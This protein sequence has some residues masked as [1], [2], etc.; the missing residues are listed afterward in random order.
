MFFE[1]RGRVHLSRNNYMFRRFTALFFILIFI[2]FDVIRYA[3]PCYAVDSSVL[4]SRGVSFLG[5]KSIGTVEESF[6]GVSGKTIFFIQDA[7]DSLEAQENIARIISELVKKN[8]I[9]TVFE[10]G[11][12][13]PV[14]SDRFFGFIKD[15]KI[16]QKVSYF[17]LDKLRIGGAEYAHINR[18][19]DFKLIGVESLKLYSQNIHHYQKAS[20][21]RQEVSQDLKE[22]FAQ[23]SNLA[24]QYFPKNF[25]AWLLINER[26]ADG[27][28]PLLNYLKELQILYRKGFGGRFVEQFDAKYPAISILLAAEN[29]HDP[30]LVKQLNKMNFKEVFGEVFQLEQDISSGYLQTE[31][32]RQIFTYYQELQLLG[33]LNQFKL[34][35]PEYEAVKETLEKFDT[36]KLADFA[37][38]L[39]HRSLILS[40]EWERSIKDAV[41]FYDVANQREHSIDLHVQNFIKNKTENAAVLVFGGFHASG[42]KEILRAHQIS[43]RVIL[44]RIDF[45]DKKHQ[46][47]YRQ[48]MSV[49][50]YAF[51]MPFLAAQANKPPS[52]YF[53]AATS[54]KEEFALSE[55][56]AIAS[57]VQLLGSRFVTE[58][59]EKQLAS[60]SF[61]QKPQG[62]TKKTEVSTRSETRNAKQVPRKSSKLLSVGITGASGDLGATLGRFFESKNYPLKLVFRSSDSQR[63][64]SD[65]ALREIS[66]D[67][68]ILSELFDREK[69]QS[70]IKNSAV[71]YHLAAL[72]GLDKDIKTYAENFK[73][74]GLAAVGLLKMAEELN[75]GQ[76]FIFASTQRVYGIEQ[77]PMAVQW[78]DDALK[79]MTEHS[80]LFQESNYSGAMD[81]LMM[82]ILEKHPFPEGI[83]PYELAKFF[84][85]KYIQQSKL[86]NAVAVRVSSIYGPGNLSGRK[87]Q[88]MIE[89]RLLGKTIQ[90]KREIRDYIYIQDA[91]EVLYKLGFKKN[92]PEQSIMDL[93]SGVEISAEKIWEMIVKHTPEARGKIEWQGNSIPANPQSSQWGH[94][95]L[96]RDF[97]YI[98]TGIRN[99]V[100]EAR[101]RLSLQ[102]PKMAGQ[103]RILVIDAGGTSTRM[104]VWDGEKLTDQVKFPTINY[105]S[106]Q[107]R[108]KSLDQMQELWLESLEQRI[109]MYREQ[110]PDIQS[111][112]MGFAGP[113]SEAGDL[114]ES[115][116]IW[117]AGQRRIFN[118][119]LQ[120]RWGLP[121]LV[122]NDLTAAVYRYGKSAPF[123]KMRTI[124]LITVS[125]GIGSKLFDIVHGSVVIDQRGRAGEIGHTIVD[126]ARNAIRGEGL[127]GELNAYSSGRGLANLAKRLTGQKKFQQLY[128]RSILKREIEKSGQTIETID[129]DLLTQ[130]LVASIKE[131]DDFSLQVMK[132]SIGYFIRVL[133]PFIL[134]NAPDAIVWMG[135]IAEHLGAVYLD[136]VISQLLDKGLYGYTREDLG[137][138]FIM[139]EKDDENGLRG[140]GLMV[141]DKKQKALTEAPY[142]PGYVRDV[143]DEHGHTT[144]EALARND[145]GYKNYFERGIFD[146]SNPTLANLVGQRN[147]IFV[148]EKIMADKTLLAI[149]SYAEHHK[150]KLKGSIQVLDGGEKIKSAEEVKMLTDYAQDQKLDRNGVFVV[151]GGGAIMDM[152]GM[153][154]S[155]FRRGVKYVRIPT[156]LLGQ[157]DAAVGVK[158]G[159]D[160]RTAKNFLGAFYPPEATITDTQFLDSLPQRH[161]QSGLA[162]VIKVALISNPS[163]FKTLEEYGADFLRKMPEHEK[164]TFIRE[165][166]IELLKH[167]QRDF[168]EHNLMRHVDFG[169]VLAH[170]FE[171]MTNYELT[172]GEAVAID[173]LMSAFIAHERGMLSDKDFDRI[174]ALHAKLNLPYF[175]PALNPDRAW[176]GLE[177]SKAH[178]GGRLMMVVPIGIGQTA[179]VD[180][181]RRKEVVSA[182]QF[183]Q[184]RQQQLEETTMQHRIGEN[185]PPIE[186]RHL[187]AY[188]ESLP[189]DT[190]YYLSE[191]EEALNSLCAASVQKVINIATNKSLKSTVRAKASSMLEQYGLKLENE[192][193]TVILGS[194]LRSNLKEVRFVL[195]NGRFVVADKPRTQN[196]MEIAQQLLGKEVFVFDI[197]GTLITK[198]GADPEIVSY[199]IQLLKQHKTV[200]I[201]TVR[202]LTAEDYFSNIRKGEGLGILKDIF[203]HPDFKPEMLE[204]LYAY[205][206]V[207]TYKFKFRVMARRHQSKGWVSIEPVAMAQFYKK[208]S[209]R[210][211]FSSQEE[212]F[213]TLIKQALLKIETDFHEEFDFKVTDYDYEGFSRSAKIQQDEKS[214]LYFPRAKHEQI[215][216]WKLRVMKKGLD[217]QL[218]KILPP[219]F[220]KKLTLRVVW[221][222]GIIVVK[223]KNQ[224]N[225]A[226]LDVEAE[227]Q[228]QGKTAFFADEF[229]S[230]GVDRLV[231]NVSGVKV[232]SAAPP[233]PGQTKMVQLKSSAEESGPSR[234]KRIL[235]A[236]FILQSRMMNTRSEIRLSEDDINMALRSVLI[237]NEL[238]NFTKIKPSSFRIFKR[239]SNRLGSVNPEWVMRGILGKTS[240]EKIT[241]DELE[242]FF[243]QGL[244]RPVSILYRPLIRPADIK[245]SNRLKKGVPSTSSNHPLSPVVAETIAANLVEAVRSQGSGVTD[246]LKPDFILG[247]YTGSLVIGS[248]FSE[249]VGVPFV[250]LTKRP[251]DFT[252][253]MGKILVQIPEPHMPRDNPEYFSNVTMPPQSTFLFIDDEM[254]TGEVIKNTATALWGNLGAKIV[255]T[256]VV[257]Q[258]SPKASNVLSQLKIPFAALDHL[259]ES[260]VHAAEANDIPTLVP[261]KQALSV[262]EWPQKTEDSVIDN[263]LSF[264]VEALK[265]SN[266][267]VFFA[268][269]PFRGMSIALDPALAQQAGKKINSELEKKL[270][271]I[272]L[273]RQE[274]YKKGKTLFLVGTTPS[275][276]LAAL[277]ASRETRLP[278]IGAMN[279]PEPQAYSRLHI[280]DVVNYINLDGNAYSMF[281]LNQGD[282]VILVTGELTD[283][284]EQLRLIKALRDKGVDV[285]ASV[286]V[287]ENVHYSGR[288]EVEGYLH[289][290]V[291]TLK[292]YDLN[293]NVRKFNRSSKAWDALKYAVIQLEERAKAINPDAK[294]DKIQV[295]PSSLTRGLILDG[296]DLDE[297]FVF[298]DGLSQFELSQ[299]QD[300]FTSWLNQ[301]NIK[302]VGQNTEVPLLLS[303]WDREANIK[304]YNLEMLPPSVTIYEGGRFI[305]P[306]QI[307][308]DSEP[309]RA[310]LSP[311]HVARISLFLSTG[312]MNP[313]FARAIARRSSRSTPFLSQQIETFINKFPKSALSPRALQWINFFDQQEQLNNRK[314]HLAPEKI[315]ELEPVLQELLEKRMVRILDGRLTLVWRHNSVRFSD[316]FWNNQIILVGQEQFLDKLE[317]DWR[318]AQPEYRELLNAPEIIFSTPWTRFVSPSLVEFAIQ[319]LMKKKTLN[320]TEKQRL[321]ESFGSN[322]AFVLAAA[323]KLAE[324]REHELKI[325]AQEAI[326]QSIDRPAQAMNQPSAYFG[327]LNTRLHVLLNCYFRW[328]RNTN[329]NIDADASWFLSQIAV[330]SRYSKIPPVIQ[331]GLLYYLSLIYANVHSETVQDQIYEFTRE[332]TRNLH[333]FVRVTARKALMKMELGQSRSEV[334]S[335]GDSVEVSA[336]DDDESRRLLYSEFERRRA[337]G[338]PIESLVSDWDGTLIDTAGS[339]NQIRADVSI[340]LNW[341][342]QKQK[343]LVVTTAASYARFH[344]QAFDP[345]KNDLPLKPSER[346]QVFTDTV[347]YLNDRPLQHRS[348]SREK[349]E[350]L[351]RL[352]SGEKWVMLDDGRP[353]RLSYFK[354]GISYGQAVKEAREI[355]KKLPAGVFSHL[356]LSP[357]QS[358]NKWIIKIYY[359]TKAFVLNYP[360]AQKEWIVPEKTVLLGD[361]LGEFGIDAPLFEKA[362]NKTLKINVGHGDDRYSIN[363]KGRNVDGSILVLEAWVASTI[364]EDAE[365]KSR[366]VAEIF[367]EFSHQLSQETKLGDQ[368]KNK[369]ILKVQRLLFA[370]RSESRNDS[371]PKPS[372]QEFK[373][374]REVFQA[375]I[376]E[377]VEQKVRSLRE[378]T[379]YDSVHIQTVSER[380]GFSVNLIVIRMPASLEYGVRALIVFRDHH[381]KTSVYYPRAFGNVSLLSISENPVKEFNWIEFKNNF[382]TAQLKLDKSI[383]LRIVEN[384][385]FGQQLNLTEM[386]Y[387]LEL[388]WD[389][390]SSN[391]FER[392]FAWLKKD[393]KNA[394]LGRVLTD[395]RLFQA[396]AAGNLHLIHMTIGKKTI[397][398]SR[399][400]QIHVST[401]AMGAVVHST[402]I[403]SDGRRSLSEGGRVVSLV[404]EH[405]KNIQY[406]RAIPVNAEKGDYYIAFQVPYRG[407]ESNTT[408]NWINFFGFG[409]AYLD[410]AKRFSVS[411][412]GRSQI[413]F[414]AIEQEAV[415]QYQKTK[416]L[417]EILAAQSS[418]SNSADWDLFWKAFVL[419][420]QKMPILNQIFFEIMKNY[421]GLYQND[422]E[423]LELFRQYGDLNQKNYYDVVFETDPKSRRSFNTQLFQPNFSLLTESLKKRIS[424]FDE[425]VFKRFVLNR[426]S[427]FLGAK[428]LEG[429]S[430][431]EEVKRFH[432]LVKQAPNF[433]GLLHYNVTFARFLRDNPKL[434]DSYQTVL[435][436]VLQEGYEERNITVPIM[437]IIAPTGEAGVWQR[438]RVPVK[439]FNVAFE[440]SSDAHVYGVSLQ[441]SLNIHISRGTVVSHSQRALSHQNEMKEKKSKRSEARELTTEEVVK[442]SPIITAKLKNE[443][444]F[445]G[446]GARSSRVASEIPTLPMLKPQSPKP[447]SISEEVWR[448]GFPL[449]VDA[450]KKTYAHAR[451]MIRLIQKQTQPVA[452]Y[453]DAEDFQNLSESQKREYL[454]VASLN[455]AV[456]IVVYNERG[457]ISDRIFE[458]LL[459]LDRVQRTDLDLVKAD[460]NFHKPNIPTI[461]LSKQ[462]LPPQELVNSLSRK[463]AFFKANGNKSGTLAAALLWAT[464]GGEAAHFQ[465]VKE[466]KGFWVVEEG[467]LDELQQTYE[468]NFVFALAA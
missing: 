226:V 168:F 351:N 247:K 157:V 411:G 114:T 202:G 77:N 319:S 371:S 280:S 337:S 301:A 110:H 36:Q 227:K 129:R 285:R 132:T 458:E 81:K 84:V 300:E 363:L 322:N 321:L 238:M 35:Q 446:E 141:Y 282:G 78:V 149:Q 260:D 72:V 122:V 186:L 273:L 279:R 287:V 345:V 436:R 419:A 323:L 250:T 373:K 283:G 386:A 224:K 431:P 408:S 188:L 455:N 220:Y 320:E 444:A 111:I 380:A 356:T 101:Q 466:E 312:E 37:V 256:G 398:N 307:Q 403:I 253:P 151:V 379:Q 346:L 20:K 424:G 350:E 27:T 134:Q 127:K 338:A 30:T 53:E 244:I 232:I 414:K 389:E 288:K 219:E 28:L 349:R 327:S 294:V 286:S 97:T 365:K 126:Y 140:A 201:A 11:Y 118:S 60:G 370:S 298:V 261:F 88:R 158:V 45:V 197:D 382:S 313:S 430:L 375:R 240:L 204:Q 281:G 243:Y 384:L 194:A 92:V 13:G 120:K 177:E 22:L 49:G 96:E 309:D 211:I 12:E 267:G 299:I 329:K 381:S 437:G 206:S 135:S 366:P 121:V 378:G 268:D 176:E 187:Q 216:N 230:D 254:T 233:I 86:R 359:V 292:K 38:A 231:L 181:L 438:E 468:N 48:L 217:A 442:L 392:E 44:P 399:E 457:Q 125:S 342:V 70:V 165:A 248:L 293:E 82:M 450:N 456:R 448:M 225:E 146:I 242:L 376:A 295:L 270:G 41:R 259:S 71:F 355:K 73:I 425:Q 33:K 74:N 56:R 69:M 23:I 209:K 172:H 190:T 308:S 460:K 462:I 123:S 413:H 249:A 407:P 43:Y 432:D 100:D 51:E 426:F 404:R 409:R 130:L 465:G 106:D 258:S 421:I 420:R 31:R 3:A 189:E 304:K 171:S 105:A 336:A 235:R 461:H 402:P 251:Y 257:L 183:L 369:I 145:I 218:K 276:I 434:R 395:K 54:G 4:G 143:V 367:E 241:D 406:R 410:T 290:P 412:I 317:H 441:K 416:E 85:E 422:A 8:G 34:S 67:R 246:K 401:L 229:S 440:K 353:P 24:Y 324:K 459:K 310:N 360:F 433:A 263:K 205:T 266:A 318:A 61:N 405:W 52:I 314:I 296:S 148:V 278:L 108:D 239:E 39:T 62:S 264:S 388:D 166:A 66:D 428:L 133:G 9:E 368:I 418:L 159:I 400:K 192:G 397:L 302:L 138:M 164:Q 200:A 255:G 372:L 198:E 383:I 55:L 29:R 452:V 223:N 343:K 291:I 316:Q 332:Q 443:K 50:H 305:E 32:D 208:H 124:A 390:N 155:Q 393:L 170:K 98:E 358:K 136:E 169:H 94:Q 42:I 333:F 184:K 179:F 150:L 40:R 331:R 213:L 306:E 199:L 162:E 315:A 173:I 163:L 427:T 391:P 161:I 221:K 180:S 112:S 59:V 335:G 215:E 137:R 467:L 93:A 119:E 311:K 115:A 435:A 347:S 19:A 196:E 167:L 99:Q 236:Y 175:H 139:G 222:R 91:I 25:K 212:G 451:G 156:T 107:A 64:Y 102:A 361:D 234:I 275:G 47:Y 344:V 340:L 297:M 109:R 262:R 330:P 214:I 195:K 447:E 272:G 354:S 142:D 89:A 113:V 182:L 453:V 449:A 116:V 75:P 174:V 364:Q 152:V 117:G 14:P 63:K 429:A 191:I 341:L 131:K 2:F 26:F 68:F 328:M 228:A 334:L 103:G 76:R 423:S 385:D 104:A 193:N 362:G 245:H 454:L 95:L 1:N 178:K 289:A 352:M 269:H 207:G 58:A 252:L 21:S 128:E 90:E 5:S 463:V 396:D 57:S 160:Y 274:Y 284:T 339:N 147:V 357:F 16:K 6:E 237:H 377:E 79:V 394:P 464:S 271:K 80:Q 87:I 417:L 7:H 348:F 17:L 445:A 154:A 210:K 326:L 415:D 15:S 83:Y 325:W 65:R 277:P 303:N 203:D 46:K 439:A 144:V 185:S 265:T 153:A 387:V 10:E 374:I 18:A